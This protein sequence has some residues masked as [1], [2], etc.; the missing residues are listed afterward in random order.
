M[1]AYSGCNC[2]P[3]RLRQKVLPWA[4]IELIMLKV[5]FCSSHRMACFLSS[6]S[7]CRFQEKNLILFLFM[8][9][10]TYKFLKSKLLL[11]KEQLALEILTFFVLPLNCF[12]VFFVFDV[13]ILC[14][15]FLFLKFFRY[16][17]FNLDNFF[18]SF[19]RFFDVNLLDKF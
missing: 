11:W 12:L 7:V 15:F 9:L 13:L 5:V 10:S 1:R 3:S 14:F 2:F 16:K 18:D 17:I 6:Q 4:Y 8:N 19:L